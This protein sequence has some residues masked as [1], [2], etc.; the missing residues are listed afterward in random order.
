MMNKKYYLIVFGCQMNWSD[1]ERLESILTA[2]GYEKTN[3]ESEADLIAVVACS[4]RQAAI[5]RVDGKSRQWQKKRQAG[6]LICILSGCVLE[7]DKK[8][9]ADRFDF[10]F[11]PEEMN[12]LPAK[13]SELELVLKDDYLAIEPEYNSNFKAYVPIMTGCN[14]FCSYCVVP[15]TR[16]REKS[17]PAGEILA[18]CRDLIEK[19]YKEIT[20]LGQ[21]VNSYRNPDLE[22]KEIGDF[23]QLLKAI[24]EIPGDYWL[25]FLTSHPKDCSKNLIQVMAEGDHI[26]PHLHL[27]IQSGDE[28]ILKKMNRHYTPEHFISLVKDAREAL[29]EIAIST[30][31]IVGFPGESLEAFNN[32]A[33]MMEEA[34]F[35]M[36]YLSQYSPRIGTAASK[37][38]NDVPKKEKKRREEELNEVLKITAK[39][40]NDRF[41]GLKTRVL[42]DSW[43][44]G[45]C[46]GKNAQ[47]KTVAFEGEKELIGRFVEVEVIKVTP[48]GFTGQALT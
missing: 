3:T 33:K 32:T 46:F 45:K 5:D 15:Y 21:N 14:N 4:V 29:K 25:R 24:D 34:K 6:R 35:D 10:I 2:S 39:E 9:L 41:K 44:S 11:S 38:K 22:S 43:R 23:P 20:L 7:R 47:F 26:A 8:K 28:E 1:S 30:D 13:I 36:A 19:G 37:L 42:V 40:H 16:G 48:W 27:A 18:Q 31:I 12:E 17:R